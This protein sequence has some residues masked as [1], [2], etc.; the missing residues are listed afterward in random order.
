M[1]DQIAR[2]REA[3]RYK[4]LLEIGQSLVTIT[5]LDQL[6]RKIID[7]LAKEIQAERAL[8]ILRHPITGEMRIA[9]STANVDTSTL[10]DAILFSKTI[11]SDVV[12][13][14][15][16]IFSRD[17]IKDGTYSKTDSV[18]N[19]K[20]RSL[21]CVPLIAKQ[22]GDI[23]G[24]VYVDNRSVGNIFSKED[25]TLLES[26]AT[27][28]G[29]AIENAHL[30][31]LA[32]MDELTKCYVRRY[33]EQRVREEFSRAE[34]Q[35]SPLALL[36]IDVDQFKEINDRYGHPL[37]DTVLKEITTMIK[38]NLRTYDLL[39]R[40][41]GDEFAIILPEVTF[42]DAYRVSEKIR[43]ACSQLVFP[44]VQSSTTIS[45]GIACYPLH[46]VNNVE[47][48]LKKADVALYK[49]KQL[50][51]NTSFFYGQQEM[52]ELF[53]QVALDGVVANK[54]SLAELLEKMEV[55]NRGDVSEEIDFIVGKSIDIL[56]DLLEQVN[57]LKIMAVQ[58]NNQIHQLDPASNKIADV[59]S[60]LQKLVNRQSDLEHVIQDYTRMLQDLPLM[61]N[62]H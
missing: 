19:L 12:N 56:K 6:L 20:I 26:F 55:E 5:D 53:G 25:L 42:Q 59:I 49:A 13:K 43:A 30:Y 23:I 40:L 28:A 52:L 22:N 24:T 50:G 2:Q 39:A 62:Q 41:G 54:M 44:G 8:I 37:G 27:L 33:F 21:M 51:R 11:V 46:H 3:D 57:H 31:E 61:K 9:N 4:S 45:I 47:S 1:K 60:L 34:R 15:K 10:E 16:S 7:V 58:M 32:I 29:M 14:G 35:G 18:M 48:L 17:V 38:R 36:L